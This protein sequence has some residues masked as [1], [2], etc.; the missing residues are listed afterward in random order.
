M[1]NQQSL[2]TEALAAY[3]KE[4]TRVS[5]M[6]DEVPGLTSNLTEKEKQS[7]ELATISE[8]TNKLESILKDGLAI[9]GII[10]K[11]VLG[12]NNNKEVM[13]VYKE[14]SKKVYYSLY[15]IKF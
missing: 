13:L 8:F 3:K 9:G 1:N 7:C 14:N 11:V 2:K 5:K 4:M 6:L 12:Y 15:K 10:K